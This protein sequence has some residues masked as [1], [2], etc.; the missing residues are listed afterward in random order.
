MR[1]TLPPRV[2]QPELPSL[3]DA[4]LG[5]LPSDSAPV[6]RLESAWRRVA[7]GDEV[8]LALEPVQDL[9]DQSFA[10]LMQ[11]LQRPL[12][13]ALN[14][15]IRVRLGDGPELDAS[16]VPGLVIDPPPRVDPHGA[17]F[18]PFEPDPPGVASL[19]DT[20]GSRAR[21]RESFQAYR[22]RMA[23]LLKARADELRQPHLYADAPVPPA[24]TPDAKVAGADSGGGGPTGTDLGKT[25]T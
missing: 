25:S 11:A 4:L 7:A 20:P 14:L 24:E 10:L 18:S 13:P 15:R 8:E 5:A 19:E 3:V 6:Q 9:T 21:R 17:G 1:L 2:V 22:L 16:V 23:Q 12:Q